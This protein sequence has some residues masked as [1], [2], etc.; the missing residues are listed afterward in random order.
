MISP[1]RLT[2]IEIA[3]QLRHR[4][5]QDTARRRVE[6]PIEEVDRLIGE[7]EELLLVGR[8]RVPLSMENRL[9]RLADNLPAHPSDLHSGV[10]II[11]LMDQLFDLQA[12]LL[13]RRVDRAA[14]PDPDDPD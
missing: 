13:G 2:N 14:F 7:C 4:I 3:E 9:Q 6:R 5:R 8:K 10:T 1:L 12:D 11:H